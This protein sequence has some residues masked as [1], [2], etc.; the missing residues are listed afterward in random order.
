MT[1]KRDRA[2]DGLKSLM[3]GKVI[4][5]QNYKHGFIKKASDTFIAYEGAL[6]TVPGM[7]TSLGQALRDARKE[8]RRS[9]AQVGQ[10]VGVS[11]AA[12]QQWET[13]VTRPTPENLAA[14]AKYLETDARSL[15]ALLAKVDD[16]APMTPATPRQDDPAPNAIIEGAEPRLPDLGGPRDVE[17]LGI[18][19]GGDGEDDGAF[20]FNGQVVDR[21]T[22]PPGIL[23]RRDV[24]A[25]RVS[26]TSMVP[27]YDHGERIFAERRRPAPGEYAVVELHPR[28]EGRAGRGYIKRLVSVNS[29]KVIVE[30]FNP[31]KTLEFDRDQ[32][33]AVHRVIPWQELLGV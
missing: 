21:V 25:L 8:R 22:R 11:T 18:A 26:N 10:A 6:L 16:A 24:F 30:Q 31:P 1:P 5:R 20:E 14:A 9:M 19:V 15:L 23:H 27:K 33:K 17:E 32:V 4:H 3:K 2:A 13:N 28:E 7:E 29:A 12:V